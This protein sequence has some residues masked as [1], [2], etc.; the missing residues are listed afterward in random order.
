M[1]NNKRA[2][3]IDNDGLS[4]NPVIIM[5]ISPTSVVDFYDEEEATTSTSSNSTAS[6]SCQEL[7]KQKQQQQQNQHKQRR[8]SQSYHNHMTDHVSFY[9]LY[10]LLVYIFLVLVQIGM[11]VVT[12]D[13]KWFRHQDEPMWIFPL[14]V[15]VV[16]ILTIEV[17]AHFVVSTKFHPNHGCVMQ[18]IRPQ[19]LI[20]FAIVVF[21]IT[22]IVL[23]VMEKY[24]NK[25]NTT[26]Q[27]DTKNINVHAILGLLRD[28]LRI[29]RIGEFVFI[30][31]RVL[32]DP[33]WHTNDSLSMKEVL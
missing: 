21:S 1:A 5:S 7:N 2:S 13:M 8:E 12:I 30:L 20:D 18:N 14:D 9:L 33:D 11:L 6:S 23:E 10:F 25:N 16:S 26:T 24:N 22:M 27:E 3:L 29:V 4:H 19:L 17:S 15:M 31:K 32:G 28:I